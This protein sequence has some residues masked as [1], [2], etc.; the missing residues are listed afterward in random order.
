MAQAEQIARPETVD[1]ILD[2]AIAALAR[3][4]LRKLSMS[5]ICAAAGISRGTLYRYF[6][7]KEDV[8]EAIAQHVEQRFREAM[9]EAI[10]Q[11]PDLERRVEVVLRVIQEQG[12]TSPGSL[13]VLE[14]EPGFALQF[15]R[16]EFPNLVAI[17]S[18]AVAPALDQHPL[19]VNAPVDTPH[20]AELILRVGMCT[21]LVPSVDSDETPQRVGALWAHL[22]ALG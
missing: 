5:D 12:A 19:G 7:T 18:D 15:L 9:D 2:G 4:G 20:L 6:K 22:E 17:V 14:V 11:E 16:R 1:R 21:Y 13:S 10:A 8:L 3:R